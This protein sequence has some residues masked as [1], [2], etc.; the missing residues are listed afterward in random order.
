MGSGALAAL[1]GALL[2]QIG[3]NFANDV[4]DSEKGADT[5]DAAGPAARRTARPARSPAQMKRGMLVAFALAG[6]VGLLP[7]VPSP[8]GR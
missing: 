7:R 8:A 2:L 3:C 6:L 1:V 5:D 4:Y